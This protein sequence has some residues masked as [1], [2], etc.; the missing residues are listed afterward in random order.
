MA[1]N[2]IFIDRLIKQISFTRIIREKFKKVSL[3]VL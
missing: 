2:V 3:N 1:K